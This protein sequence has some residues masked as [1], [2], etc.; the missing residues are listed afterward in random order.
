MG[1]Q[2]GLLNRIS[3]R[4]PSHNWDQRLRDVWSV[5][6]QTLHEYKT[7]A[8]RLRAKLDD[9]LF[10]AE[11]RLAL[12]RLGSLDF[13]KEKGTDWSWRPDIWRGPARV[14]GLAGIENGVQLA[15]G[16]AIYHDCHFNDLTFRQVRNTRNDDR[17]AFGMRLDV[18]TFDGSFLSMVLDMPWESCDNLKKSHLYRFNMRVE[19]ERPLEIFVRLNVKHG[20]NVEQIVREL[21]PGENDA[22]LEFDLAYADI[23]EKRVE[24]IWFDVIFEGPQMNQVT[25]RDV[26]IARLRRAGL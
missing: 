1:K 9:L 13:Q 26:T 4:S 11:D 17:A 14:P 16:T 22:A 18:F 6:L 5:D 19:M 23:N 10:V 20:P 24:K 2:S 7:D 8:R 15:W 21:P 25:L 12:P 3:K